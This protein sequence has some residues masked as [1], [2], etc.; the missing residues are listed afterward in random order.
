MKKEKQSFM[1]KAEDY[2]GIAFMYAVGIFFAVSILWFIGSF[3][4]HKTG[5]IKDS[6]SVESK[7]IASNNAEVVDEP[8]TKQECIDKY[9]TGGY[10][11]E[12]NTAYN[13][14][15]N[16]DGSHTTS[17]ADEDFEELGRDIQAY[18][19][20]NCNIKG[21]ISYNTGE[22]IYHVPGQKYYDATSIDTAYGEKIFCS[23][24]EAINAGWR[25]S[26]E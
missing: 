11:E 14:Y 5:L 24:Q 7:P 26:Y 9:G 1:A 25:K 16:D 23:E 12:T 6:A 18:N 2:L 8:K 15:C 17:D 19:A 13:I 21:N 20:E 3:I 22:K 4:G 10:S